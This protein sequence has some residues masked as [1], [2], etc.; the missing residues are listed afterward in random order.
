MSMTFFAL[1]K[2]NSFDWNKSKEIFYNL[3]DIQVAWINEVV[4]FR[5]R[6]QE[7]EQEKL[8]KTLR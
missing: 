4:E 5:K 1:L 2:E 6:E 7:K 3:T 8:K